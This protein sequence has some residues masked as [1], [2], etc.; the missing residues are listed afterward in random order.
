MKWE[1]Y[2]NKLMQ[3]YIAIGMTTEIVLLNI[4]YIEY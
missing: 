3:Y 2:I 4:T 1:T